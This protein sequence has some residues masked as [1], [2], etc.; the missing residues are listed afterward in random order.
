[1]EKTSVILTCPSCSAQ[2]FADEKAIGENG[3][4]VRCASCSH[5]WFVQPELSLEEE[6]NASDLSR[7]KV[8]RMRMASAS[9]A[10]I[11]PHL[12]YRE[13]E[14]SRRR[15]GSRL[16]AVAAWTGTAGVFFALGVLA[17]AK[18]DDVV[19]VFPEASSAYAMA[20]LDVNRFGLEFSDMVADR[21]FDGT[22]PVLTVSGSI[23]NITDKFQAVPNVRVD[24]RDDQGR[25]VESILI[26]PEATKIGPGEE[27]IFTSR[28]DSPSLDAYDLAVTFVE[29]GNTTRLAAPGSEIDTHS[30]APDGYEEPT[31][32]AHNAEHQGDHTENETVA[33][34]P[35]AVENE[36]HDEHS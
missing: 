33:N 2:Y 28:V 7:E 3:R 5:S 19:K 13:K 17:I 8:E 26:S 10:D 30:A 21:E 23:L 15:T 18:R 29:R 34:D 31:L 9:S 14:M 22:I 35:H 24:L 25:D 27:V 20:G 16:A 12:A 6:I 1:V 32:E 11:A 4:T 36:H